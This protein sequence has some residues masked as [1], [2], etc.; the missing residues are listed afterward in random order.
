MLKERTGQIAY[1][2]EFQASGTVGLVFVDYM[3]RANE[4]QGWLLVNGDPPLIDVDNLRALPLE[5]MRADSA[6]ASLAARYPRVMM[7]PGDR[8]G[9]SRP[10]VEPLAS[11]GQR[12]VIAYRLLNG[13]HA[14]ARLGLARFAFD[15]DESGRLSGTR[16]VGIDEQR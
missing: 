14:C 2:R 4:N 15:F 16:F 1:A 9:N 5:N 12:F 11:R 13:C 8:G 6:Y 7:F 3:L 10:E